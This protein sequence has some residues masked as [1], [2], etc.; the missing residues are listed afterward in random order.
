MMPAPSPLRIALVTDFALPRLGGIETHVDELAGALLARG[1]RPTVITAT[2]GADAVTRPYAIR[3]LPGPVVPRLGLA[4][5]SSLAGHVREAIGSGFD[6]VHVHLSLVSP[7]GFAAMHA[8]ARLG[9]PCVIT[10]HSLVG[11]LAPL[12]R[13]LGGQLDLA[14]WPGILSA[15]SDEA[16]RQIRMAIP[17]REVRRLPNAVHL[18]FWPRA[19]APDADGPLVLVSAMRLTGRKRPL[20]LLQAA[21]TAQRRIG[22]RRQIRL[23]IAGAGG[24]RERLARAASRACLPVELLPR[25]THEE[26]RR[27]YARAHAFVLPT[28]QEAFGRAALEARAAGLPV[29]AMAE[30]GVGEYIRHGETGLIAQDDRE[31]AAHIA[32]LATDDLLRRKLTTAAPELDAYD[33]T[34]VLLAHEQAYADAQSPG[35]NSEGRI[36]LATRGL[37][38]G[39]GQ[40]SPP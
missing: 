22:A 31:L 38:A 18:G 25:L 15:V 33:W 23:I 26:L 19:G 14:H 13:W 34:Q 11:T 39:A 9:L 7:V 8:A 1:H 16:A 36:A 2:P 29:L 37:R 30:G 21:E 4:V 17:G 12:L 3:R 28:R 20:A 24:Q 6:V 10:V 27:L 40:A 5:S 35:G 32:A